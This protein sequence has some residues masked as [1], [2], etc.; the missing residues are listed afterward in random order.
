MSMSSSGLPCS[1]GRVASAG[2]SGR[3]AR[4]ARVVAANASQPPDRSVRPGRVEPELAGP[5]HSSLGMRN[6][7]SL[8]RRR[9]EGARVAAARTRRRRRTRLLV[10]GSA[11][12][13]QGLSS[14]RIAPPACAPRGPVDPGPGLL[15]RSSRYT[16]RHLGARDPN[17]QQSAIR[18]PHTGAAFR[19]ERP[20]VRG[21]APVHM[22]RRRGGEGDGE[23]VCGP[24]SMIQCGQWT[25]TDADRYRF[26]P[27]VER[28]EAYRYTF[29]CGLLDT[30]LRHIGRSTAPCMR[31]S[32]SGTSRSARWCRCCVSVWVFAGPAWSRW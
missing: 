10:G 4:E 29:R 14:C 9:C 20:R 17:R 7:N 21:S 27:T 12:P 30:G 26:K 15:R 24:V 31:S 11:D 23:N 28:D 25:G 22:R 5:R 16:R 32:G 13:G 3:V 8:D 6:L 18:L 1:A 19:A 2:S